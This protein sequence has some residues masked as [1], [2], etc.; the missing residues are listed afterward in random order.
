MIVC[1]D[2]FSKLAP[3][4]LQKTSFEKGRDPIDFCEGEREKTRLSERKNG[5]SI[6]IDYGR[7][8]PGPLTSGTVA[9]GTIRTRI[10]KG[11]SSRWTMPGG[12]PVA[13]GTIRTRI[14]KVM[15]LDLPPEVDQG[16][17]GD[18]PHEDTERAKTTYNNWS[19]AR[20]AEGTIRTRILKVNG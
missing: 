4:T 14:L 1:A 13:E 15:L 6:V 20:V 2:A 18:D 3:W 8:I 11:L 5:A 10:L 12:W 16:C 9:E 7:S 17:R 19:E